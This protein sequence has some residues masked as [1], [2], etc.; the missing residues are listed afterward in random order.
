[1]SLEDPDMPVKI[2]R[3]E[4]MELAKRVDGIIGGMEHETA[5]KRA[6]LEADGIDGAVAC[7]EIQKELIPKYGPRLRD[8]VGKLSELLSDRVDAYDPGA[9]DAGKVLGRLGKQAVT[10]TKALEQ[11]AKALKE[12]ATPALPDKGA[13]FIKATQN[14]FPAQQKPVATDFSDYMDQPPET[15]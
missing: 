4:A 1:M 13:T 6:A 14:V 3:A 15:K 10:I 5:M 12:W 11:G 7:Y 8:A 2:A 9:E